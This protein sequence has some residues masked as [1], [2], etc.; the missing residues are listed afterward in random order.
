MPGLY[1]PPADRTPANSLEDLSGTCEHAWRRLNKTSWCEGNKPGHITG[2]AGVELDK[3]LLGKSGH[4]SLFGH[5]L[6]LSKTKTK[7]KAATDMVAMS[8]TDGC[9]FLCEGCRF[10]WG[11]KQDEGMLWPQF[12]LTETCELC[13]SGV[14]G[15]VFKVT[16]TPRS[17]CQER[18]FTFSTP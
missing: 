6:N 2:K 16:V 3:V 14:C 18:N 8:R 12:H 10:L 13:A 1:L 5:N 9:L 7:T 11:V 15:C 17:E 4:P